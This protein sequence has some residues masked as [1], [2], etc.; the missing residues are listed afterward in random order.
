[1]PRVSM[2]S[3]WATGRPWRR[4]ERLVAGLHFVGAGG[5]CGGEL[6]DE[7]DDGVD[8]GIDAF[9]LFEVRGKGFAG[10]ELLGS[11][12]AAISTAEVKQSE[13]AQTRRLA[14][15]E[16]SRRRRPRRGQRGPLDVWVGLAVQ[17][18][19]KTT[20]SSEN[21]APWVELVCDECV[22]GKLPY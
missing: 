21:S 14:L 9:D 4:A 18:A 7:G 17:Q 1:M 20:L 22:V 8:L 6:G 5:R 15:R 16:E 13:G 12:Q 2:R 3:L 19:C 11:D 10:G